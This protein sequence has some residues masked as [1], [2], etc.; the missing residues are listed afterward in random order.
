MRPVR[1]RRYLP[2]QG[3]DGRHVRRKPARHPQGRRPIR[4]RSSRPDP[5][6]STCG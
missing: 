3:Q 2:L 5:S 6:G 4:I 1:H